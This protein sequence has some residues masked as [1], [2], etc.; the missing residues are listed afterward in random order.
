MGTTTTTTTTTTTP[1]TTTPEETTS[2]LVPA[3]VMTS[4]AAVSRDAVE[5]ED[6]VGSSARVRETVGQDAAL[7]SGGRETVPVSQ[8]VSL[9]LLGLLWLH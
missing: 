4:N 2:I 3:V 9:T 8:T 5:P 1:E 6:A 7:R